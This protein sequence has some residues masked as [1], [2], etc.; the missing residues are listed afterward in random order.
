MKSR[1]AWLTYRNAGAGA[2]RKIGQG[3]ARITVEGESVKNA[4]I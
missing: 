1:G 4:D 2:I 3:Y